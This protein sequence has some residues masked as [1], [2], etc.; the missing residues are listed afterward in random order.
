[1]KTHFFLIIL[2]YSNQTNNTMLKL[3][4]L[5]RFLALFERQVFPICRNHLKLQ[6]ATPSRNLNMFLPI[7]RQF[8]PEQFQVWASELPNL[9]A[10]PYCPFLG[11]IPEA[12]ALL[13]AFLPKS[14]T[15]ILLYL[16]VSFHVSQTFC[17]CFRSCFSCCRLAY[18]VLLKVSRVFLLLAPFSPWL[19]K[20]WV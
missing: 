14:T 13:Q 12:T 19:A 6:L 2:L 7:L 18:R 3:S 16:N 5:L 17:F 9:P 20:G 4:M 1:M 11:S 10:S 8:P 15:K